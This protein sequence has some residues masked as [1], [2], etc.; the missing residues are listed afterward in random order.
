VEIVGSAK[1]YL[2]IFVLG[3]T[4]LSSA[5]ICTEYLSGMGYKNLLYLSEIEADIYKRTRVVV[6]ISRDKRAIGT[7]Y[8]ISAVGGNEH[9]SRRER[10][11]SYQQ[12]ESLAQE[13]LVEHRIGGGGIH[14]YRRFR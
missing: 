13:W 10:E 1:K 6:R 5:S 9:M 11:F 8:T 7:S 3:L 14:G 12:A 4:P 2:I